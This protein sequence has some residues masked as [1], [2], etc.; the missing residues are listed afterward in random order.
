MFQF[1]FHF[2]SNVS[3]FQLFQFLWT[4]DRDEAGKLGT[5]LLYEGGKRGKEGGKREGGKKGEE[6]KRKGGKFEFSNTAEAPFSLKSTTISQ[7]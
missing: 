7:V 6:Q 4:Y 3:I 2:V 1:L 5:V